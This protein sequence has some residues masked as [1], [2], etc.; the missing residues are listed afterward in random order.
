[1]GVELLLAIPRTVFKNA[2]SGIGGVKPLSVDVITL[3]GGNDGKVNGTMFGTEK[4]ILVS[5][6]LVDK[7]FC[8]R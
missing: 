4:L 7:L 6:V 3:V 2:A 1:M 8:H 5:V